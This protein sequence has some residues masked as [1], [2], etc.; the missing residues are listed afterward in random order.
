MLYSR[1]KVPHIPTTFMKR[2]L[3]LVSV[4]VALGAT[5]QAANSTVKLSN[6]H[7]CCNG[8]VKGADKAIAG[9]PGATAQSDKDA[10][11][12]TIT[13]PD[14]ATAQKAVD[15]LVAG[16]YFGTANDSAIKVKAKSG[17][18]KKKVQSLKVSG[19]HLC[20]GKCVTSV[21]D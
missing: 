17:A 19:V 14:T 5:A 21:N 11:T 13:A 12:V 18:K 1:P 9:V 16:G 2:I 3:I 20:C 7:L 8:C 15:A 6:V 10:S 4:L